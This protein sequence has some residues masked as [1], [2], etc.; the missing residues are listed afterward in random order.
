MC[1]CTI[2]Y[3]KS[4]LMMSTS[5]IGEVVADHPICI[6]YTTLLECHNDIFVYFAFSAADG[7]KLSFILY[8]MKGL[9]GWPTDWS[10]S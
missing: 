3:G 6:N 1:S 9:I 10:F 4:A 2:V 7:L 5:P 8:M